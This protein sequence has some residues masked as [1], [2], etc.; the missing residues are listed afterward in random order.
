MREEKS[1]LRGL[2]VS[3]ETA[4]LVLVDWQVRLEPAMEAERLAFARH[5]APADASRGLWATA[6]RG[7]FLDDAAFESSL[8]LTRGAVRLAET[9]A[10]LEFALGS[11]ELFKRFFSRWLKLHI[12]ISMALYVLLGLHIWAT[13]YFGLRWLT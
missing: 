4:A 2:R 5:G 8:G 12:A 3:P 10:D 1:S 7:L 9:Q 13:I 11:H 6:W